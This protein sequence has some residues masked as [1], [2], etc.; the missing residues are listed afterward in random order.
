MSDTRADAGELLEQ[1]DARLN[2]RQTLEECR[3]ERLRT[4]E[5]LRRRAE[6]PESGAVRAAM[7]ATAELLERQAGRPPLR[8]V[9]DRR[10]K[11]KSVTR[12]PP[13]G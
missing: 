6:L 1:L 12:R 2:R 3:L 8:A 9:P 13:A 7:L 10:M 11:A 5:G 4:A